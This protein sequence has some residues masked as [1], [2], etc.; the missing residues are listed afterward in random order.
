VI[1][2]H[3]VIDRLLNPRL[4]HRH[5][6]VR[7]LITSDV[8]SEGLSL[9]GVATVVHLDLPW[10][11]A[12]VDQRVGRAARIG[13]PVSAVR[14]VRL[15]ASV[16]ESLHD[17]LDR[18]VA[19]KR[20]RMAIVDDAV[21]SDGATLVSTLYAIAQRPAAPGSRNVWITL[22]SPRVVRIVLVAIVRI[23]T[24]RFIVVLDGGALRRPTLSDWQALADGTPCANQ[25][26]MIGAM[27]RAL[28]EHEADRELT[29]TFAD[30]RDPRVQARRVADDQL[31]RTN[32][33]SRATDAREATAHRR[34]LM[35]AAQRAAGDHASRER[36]GEDG[37][38]RILAGVTIT[39]RNSHV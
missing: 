20:R 35:H 39:P 23:D 5:D 30:A 4:R 3:D 18:L 34:R 32:R 16:P 31:T 17:S 1:S 27:R 25:P 24:G 12:R 36:T 33:V 13:A 15:P 38:I 29:Q 22:S 2:R 19:R 28:R 26:G 21:D 8:L 7:L 6:S 10:T 14:V 37:A 11:A 9:A